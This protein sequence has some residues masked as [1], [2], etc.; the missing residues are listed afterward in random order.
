MMRTRSGTAIALGVL[1][2]LTTGTVAHA[3]DA[4]V[5]A[6]TIRRE[7]VTLF[8]MS[9]LAGWSVTNMAAGTALSFT[10]DDPQAVA[11]HQMN[12]GWN[13][14]NAALAVPSLVGAQARLSSPPELSLGEAL[15]EQN[16]LEDILLFNAGIDFA[17]IAAGFYLTELARRDDADTAQLTGFGHALMLQGGFLLVFDAVVY[18]LQRGIGRDLARLADSGR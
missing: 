9:V 14:V 8:A 11:F 3:Q 2:L 15:V 1:V 6:Y 5:R 4:A 17:Y 10:S 12:A 18:F 7:R 13:I 16:R